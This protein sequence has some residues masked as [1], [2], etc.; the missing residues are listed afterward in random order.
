VNL[1]GRFYFMN[2]PVKWFLGVGL[3]TAAGL[4]FFNPALINPAVEPGH[5]L[6]ATNAPPAEIAALLHN[7]CYDCHSSETKWP[8]YSHVAPVSWFLMSHIN[9]GREA[10]NFSDWPHD[11]YAAAS[12]ALKRIGKQVGAGRMPVRSYTWMHPAARLT[13]AQRK[14]LTDWAAK[15]AERLKD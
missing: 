12:Q 6:M 2:K 1:P 15:T 3:V 9:E 7:A 5:D 13:P 8:W 10:L 4:Q 14:Q 11:D